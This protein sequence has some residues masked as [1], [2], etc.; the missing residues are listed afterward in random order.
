MHPFT[1]AVNLFR[2]GPQRTQ[3][4]F[5]HSQS[6][7]SLA[8]EDILCPSLVQGRAFTHIGRAREDPDCRIQASGQAD[9]L[10]TGMQAG[11]AENEAASAAY[12]GTLQ[13]PAVAC[14]AV[15]R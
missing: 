9:H 5:S 15:Y 7:F 13:D 12:P 8:R 4:R 3:Y 11:S 14:I 10:G 1:L 6:H 2:G